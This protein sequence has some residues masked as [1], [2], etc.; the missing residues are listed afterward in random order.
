MKNTLLTFICLFIACTQINS[1][2]SIKYSFGYGDYNMSD[3]KDYLSD[4]RSSILNIVPGLDI[5]TTD[6]FPGYQIQFLSLGYKMQKHEFGI[7]SNFLSTAGKISYADY[8]GKISTKITINGYQQGLFYRYH[9]YSLNIK[10]KQK[11]SFYG[12][13]SPSII[14][15]KIKINEEMYPENSI[16]PPPNNRD[17]NNVSFSL[18]PQLGAQYNITSHILFFVNTGYE[19]NF[20]SKISEMNNK[21]VDWSG[22]RINGG[23]GYSF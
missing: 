9:F 15:S 2:V 8:S 14:F 7:N 22:F 6:N 18:L 1:Q 13:I 5:A 16:L 11:I 19:I 23:I 3:M 21:G 20:S 17:L 10:N 4:V 12:D